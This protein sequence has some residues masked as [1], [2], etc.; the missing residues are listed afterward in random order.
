MTQIIIEAPIGTGKSFS[1]QI[2]ATE[3]GAA[4]FKC[5]MAAVLSRI[6]ERREAAGQ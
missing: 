6:E 4:M 1:E 3:A 2:L 5:A